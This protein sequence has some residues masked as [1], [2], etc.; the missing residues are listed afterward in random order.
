MKEVDNM[1]SSKDIFAGLLLDRLHLDSA[2]FDQHLFELA[3]NAG[4][5]ADI[6]KQ[7][8]QSISK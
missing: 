4:V 7:F 1:A 6:I 8:E 2:T 3:K 5:S